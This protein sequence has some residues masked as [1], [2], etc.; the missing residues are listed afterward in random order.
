MRAPPAYFGFV[1][2]FAFIGLAG[3]FL[4]A[5]IFVEI[6]KKV[7]FNLQF[8]KYFLKKWIGT[9]VNFMLYFQIYRFLRIAL[10]T[11]G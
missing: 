11:K 2:L 9:I 6:K 1:F 4:L 5:K 7:S 8:L 10:A 3:F